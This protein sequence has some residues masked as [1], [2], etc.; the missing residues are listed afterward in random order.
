MDERDFLSEFERELTAFEF[1]DMEQMFCDETDALLAE[2]MM[3]AELAGLM[4]DHLVGLDR[5]TMNGEESGTAS[6]A[7]ARRV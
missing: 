4:P 3:E 6:D 7:T 5:F 1:A 2:M